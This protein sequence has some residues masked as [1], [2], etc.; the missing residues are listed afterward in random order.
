[1]SRMSEPRLEVI[2]P[3]TMRINEAIENAS[4]IARQLSARPFAPTWHPRD[5]R[6]TF[7]FG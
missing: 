6:F 3:P 7:S 4:G 5:L 2:A 1:M